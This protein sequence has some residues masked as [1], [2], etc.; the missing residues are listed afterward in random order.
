MFS[1]AC[2]GNFIKMYGQGND[3]SESREASLRPQSPKSSPKDPGKSTF[4]SVPPPFWA[5]FFKKIYK[6]L[7]TFINF[8]KIYTEIYGFYFITSFF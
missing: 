2:D 6:I 4:K 7:K 8:L 3:F 1:N 5:I